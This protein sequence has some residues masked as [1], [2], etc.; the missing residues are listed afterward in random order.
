M[1]LDAHLL[2][3]PSVRCSSEIDRLR[4]TVGHRQFPCFASARG[5]RMASR[6]SRTRAGHEHGASGAPPPPP[7]AS[8]VLRRVPRW[9]PAVRRPGETRAPRPR[10]RLGGGPRVAPAMRSRRSDAPL[11]YAHMVLPVS[12][13]TANSPHTNNQPCLNAPSMLG[14]AVW[15]LALTARPCIAASPSEL[16][17]PTV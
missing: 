13:I 5:L 14:R 2:T 10:A 17:V 9:P 4:P 3:T 12:L 11:D 16:A 1:T 7:R 6:R 8:A 15:Q